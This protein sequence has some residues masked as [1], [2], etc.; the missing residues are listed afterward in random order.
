MSYHFSVHRNPRTIWSDGYWE[1]IAQTKCCKNVCVLQFSPQLVRIPKTAYIL[2]S[3][4]LKIFK[5]RVSVANLFSA[6]VLSVHSFSW[7]S[8]W[9]L[10]LANYHL[11]CLKHPFYSYSKGNLYLQMQASISQV[12]PRCSQICAKFKKSIFMY[13]PIRIIYSN[14]LSPSDRQCTK[15]PEKQ[16]WICF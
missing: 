2:K 13:L 15:D 12:Y 5:Y 7:L 9:A 11:L 10:T 1:I 8:P 3:Y 16:N 6:N 14:G 4:I